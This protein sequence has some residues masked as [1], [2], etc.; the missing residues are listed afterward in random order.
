[1]KSIFENVI[2]RRQQDLI[3]LLKRIDSYHIEGKLTDAERD[4]LYVRA[5]DGAEVEN[6]IDVMAKLIEL[7]GRISKLEQAE[8][9]TPTDKPEE[10]VVGKW[11]YRTDRISFEGSVYTCTA[12]EG[13]VCT[14]SPS[15][16]P[17][18]WQKEE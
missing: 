2:A 17:A 8:S 12:P 5:R 3:S 16:Y 4:D 14:W 9:N 6:S 11:Y 1:M 15:E 18:Y 13:F 7:E 10:Y